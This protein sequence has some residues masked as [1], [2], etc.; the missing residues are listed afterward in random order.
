MD[1]DDARARL[2]QAQQSYRASNLPPLPIWV[3]V[4]VG[5]LVAVAVALLGLA[6]ANIGLRLAAIA[7]AVV[8]ALGARQL[9]L[10]ARARA[11]V[12]GLRG[13]VLDKQRSIYVGA[14]ACV[15][16]ALTAP[17]GLFWVYVGLGVV[18]GTVSAVM[19]VRA[20]RR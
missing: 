11:G 5:V 19:L 18:A 10:W 7:G 20:G 17:P 1:A 2:D 6:P 14:L 4:V 15:V 9:V 13:A 16:V 3:P 12:H 8:I